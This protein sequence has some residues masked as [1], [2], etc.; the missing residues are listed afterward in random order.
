MVEPTSE[1]LF[2]PSRFSDQELIQF[3]PTKDLEGQRRR[4]SDLTFQQRQAL[5][6]LWGRHCDVVEEY[7]KSK[8]FARGSTLCPPQEPS[9]EHFLDM[10]LNEAYL[11]FL[12]RMWRGEFENFGGFLYTLAFNVA[13]DIRKEQMGRCLPEEG[14]KKKSPRPGPKIRITEIAGLIESG[15]SPLRIAA[16]SEA[17]RI[18]ASA[19][20][21][22]AEESPRNAIST[23]VIRLRC[24][25]GMSWREIA[26]RL[27]EIIAPTQ[28]ARIKRV[29]DLEKSD[30]LAIL[31]SL[32]ETGVTDGRTSDVDRT[33]THVS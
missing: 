2:N 17:E 13:L 8:I 27:P 31:R 28:G 18:L 5:D 6:E 16:A 19:L 20:H 7:L 3:L 30:S 1:S 33:S 32:R 10:C 22:H 26:E 21:R 25:E 4:P 14:K 9:K 11:A 24:A 15:A 29:R 12:R 23:R